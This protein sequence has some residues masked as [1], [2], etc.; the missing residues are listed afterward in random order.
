MQ[1]ENAIGKITENNNFLVYDDDTEK[2]TQKW[3]CGGANK[4]TQQKKV[5]LIGYAIEMVLG[6]C[7]SP[8]YDASSGI[9]FEGCHGEVKDN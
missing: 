8:I 5:H 2:H 1:D 9:G 7:L 4:S 6:L 3:R